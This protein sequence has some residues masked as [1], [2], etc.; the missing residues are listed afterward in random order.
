MTNRLNI[1]GGIVLLG[2]AG[3]L[4]SMV[5]SAEAQCLAPSRMRLAMVRP[6]VKPAATISP[7]KEA[8]AQSPSPRAEDAAAIVG[9]W[10][11]KFIAGGMVVDEGF[12]QWHSD[13]TEFDNVDFPPTTG[14]ICEGVW[15]SKGRKVAE[16]HLGW[17]FDTSANPTGYFT[18]EQN[19]KLSK[20]GQSYSG[21]FDQKFYD[22][23]GNLVNELTGEMSAT[24]FTGN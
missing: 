8:K 4:F 1:P 15:D 21:P 11:L 16:H 18:L 5:G 6:V 10:D 20:D 22:T 2:A 7:V 9:F 12:D 17:T 24:R 23:D 14:N 19:V 13:G 3:L